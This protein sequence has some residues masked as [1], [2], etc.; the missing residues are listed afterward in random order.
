MMGLPV[1]VGGRRMGRVC[2]VKLDARLLEMEGLWVDTGMR[3]SRYVGREEIELV[4]D[5]SVMARDRGRRE[6]KAG[7]APMMRAVS[8]EGE[9]LGCVTDAFLDEESLR[10][11]AVE[12]SRGFWDDMT[13]GRRRETVYQARESG[14]VVVGGRG[15][16]LEEKGGRKDED[17]QTEACG[18]GDGDWRRGG[19]VDGRHERKKDAEGTEDVRGDREEDRG[20]G[21][22]VDEV[23]GDGRMNDEE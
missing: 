6:K 16:D 19:Q 2:G 7:K 20:C 11:V 4:G 12:L 18:R 15:D 22:E 23:T 3:G 5:V 13:Q 21:G 17:E 8:P 1:I 14:D 9:R 10:V